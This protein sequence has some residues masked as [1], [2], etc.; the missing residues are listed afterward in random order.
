MRPTFLLGAE[1]NVWRRGEDD[2]SRRIIALTGNAYWYPNIKHGWYLKGG[3][4]LTDFRKTSGDQDAITSRSFALSMGTGYEV[5]VN[6]HTS[7]VPFLN[8]IASAFGSW[9]NVSDESDTRTVIDKGE[10]NAKVFL[11]QIGMGITWH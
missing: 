4:G 1:L 11:I 9:Y 7:V 2:G 5:R 6:P 3:A 8:I 10:G